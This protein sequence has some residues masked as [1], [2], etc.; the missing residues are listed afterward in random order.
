MTWHHDEPANA[1]TPAPGSKAINQSQTTT[2]TLATSQIVTMSSQSA[3]PTN[4][5]RTTH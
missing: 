1:P 2:S 5:Q 4:C 3:C